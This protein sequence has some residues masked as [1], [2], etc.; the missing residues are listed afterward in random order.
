[1]ESRPKLKDQSRR[2]WAE[3]QSKN[4]LALSIKPYWSEHEMKWSKAQR[5][6]ALTNV[7]CHGFP[8]QPER[9]KGRRLKAGRRRVDQSLNTKAERLWQKANQKPTGFVN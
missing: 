5:R 2:L 8:D 7:N 4:P 9:I 1:M 3:G 6:V